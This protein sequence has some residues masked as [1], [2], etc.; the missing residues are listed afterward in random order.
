MQSNG[1]QVSYQT[2]IDFA[3]KMRMLAAVAFVPIDH[4]ISYF[5]HLCENNAYPETA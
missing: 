4:V 1:L 3:L 2:D 5:E